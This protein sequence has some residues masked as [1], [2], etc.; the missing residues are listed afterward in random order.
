VEPKRGTDENKDWE[1][2]FDATAKEGYR[3]QSRKTGRLRKRNAGERAR[4]KREIAELKTQKKKRAKIYKNERRAGASKRP[5]SEVSIAHIT[6]T[7]QGK[8]QV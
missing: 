3:S 6:L 7:A 8:T 4:G 2:W 1:F 5:A